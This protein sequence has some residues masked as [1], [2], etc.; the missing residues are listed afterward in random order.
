MEMPGTYTL[1]AGAIGSP[2]AAIAQTPVV[3]L[4][5]M[6]AITLDAVFQYGSGGTSCILL[7]QTSFDSGYTWRDIARFDFATAAAIKIANLEGLLSKGITIYAPLAAEGVLDGVLGD[8]LR[9]VITSTGTYVNTTA[10]LRVGV[11]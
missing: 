6:T 9:A 5:G 4:D 11:R 10:S 3:S 7:V 1:F 8:C 2:L